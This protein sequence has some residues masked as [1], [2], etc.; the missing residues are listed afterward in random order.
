MSSD[1]RV[2]RRG[3]FGLGLAALSAGLAGCTFRPVYGTFAETF[4][5][6]PGSTASALAEVD[7]A[8][9]DGRVGQVLRNELDFF[10]Y[11]GGRPAEPRYRLIAN[12]ASGGG[13]LIVSQS[14][15]ATAALATVTVTYRLER[16]D[17]I[18]PVR[19]GP[20]RPTQSGGTAEP[21]RTVFSARAESTAS[22]D[23]TGQ[24]FANLR[25]LRDAQDRAAR[26]AAEQVWTRVATEIARGA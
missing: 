19:R 8:P 23:R 5:I 11:R 15:R 2:S 17:G 24:S 18:A 26:T 12:V 16:I 22:F 9:I 21:D 1:D 6:G 3:L 4:E 14:G 7:I 13:D 10:F 25:A 20:P